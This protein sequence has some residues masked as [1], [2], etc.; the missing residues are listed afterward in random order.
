MPK[1]N[2]RKQIQQQM[3]KQKISIPVMARQLECHPQ[4]LYEYFAGRKALGADKLEAM[5][6][7][8]GGRLVFEKPEIQ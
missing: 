8:L 2:L 3:K 1:I 5:L 7:I 4:T 6:R